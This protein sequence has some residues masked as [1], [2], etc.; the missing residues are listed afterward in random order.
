MPVFSD[1]SVSLCSRSFFNTKISQDRAKSTTIMDKIQWHKRA[2]FEFRRYNW[3][4]WL[5]LEWRILNLSTFAF[6]CSFVN[7]HFSMFTCQ[8][9]QLGCL[10]PWLNPYSCSLLIVANVCG[11]KL[12]YFFMWVRY[13]MPQAN[14]KRTLPVLR[15]C[16]INDFAACRLQSIDHLTI[17]AICSAFQFWTHFFVINWIWSIY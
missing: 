14:F 12:G 9:S 10:V 15:V 7:A 6:Q 8:C 1:T 5:F 3:L 16:K 2:N 13:G 4:H 11:F 17:L